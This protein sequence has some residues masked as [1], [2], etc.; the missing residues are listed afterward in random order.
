MITPIQIDSY[1]Y[2]CKNCYKLHA[3]PTRTLDF[4]CVKE[5]Q[6]ESGRERIFE[7]DFLSVCDCDQPI[8]I[9]F[10]VREHPEGILSYHSFQSRDAELLMVPRVREH[11]EIVDG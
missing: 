6:L 4:K 9:T 2:K 3:G 7:A 8:K 10:R 5:Q 1:H 11:A